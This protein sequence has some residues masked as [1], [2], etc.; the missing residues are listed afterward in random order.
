M[1]ADRSARGDRLVRVVFGAVAV[2]LVVLAFGLPVWQARLEVLQYPNRQ[3]VLTAYGDRIEG[4]VDEIAILNHYVGVK[5][6]DMGELAETVLWNP[7]LVAAIA[8]IAV[9]TVLSGWWRRGAIVLLWLIPIGVL[10]DIQ[11]RLYQ[12]GHT[13]DPAAP[14]DVEPFTP[15]VIGKVAV[16]SN[17]KTIAWPGEALW[18][19]FGAAALVTLGPMYWGFVKEFVTAGRSD[20]DGDE[21]ASPADE[22]ASVT[23]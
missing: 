4:D 20:E 23:G 3:L 21:A 18:C 7:A 9:A 22:P 15:W 8:L 14:I 16:A 1:T 2:V 6:F 17:V 5:V 11:Y 10:I 12:M 13:I 19:L